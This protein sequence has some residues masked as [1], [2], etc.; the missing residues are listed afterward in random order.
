M[1]LPHYSGQ[2][3]YYFTFEDNLCRNNLLVIPSAAENSPIT[4]LYINGVQFANT[5]FKNFNQAIGNQKASGGLV[6]VPDSLG[7]VFD[8]TYTI[9][10]GIAWP[11]FSD[12]DLTRN[13]IGPSG[14]PFPISNFWGAGAGK[15]SLYWVDL[16]WKVL[17]GN[18]PI[19]IKAT[20][21]S[22]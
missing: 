2:G 11:E 19:K 14:G 8:S 16:P 15:A 13:D 22:K 6:I 7:Q 21:G 17:G 3:F 1:E 10:K 20:S 9:N 4:N 12:V 5:A 18:T